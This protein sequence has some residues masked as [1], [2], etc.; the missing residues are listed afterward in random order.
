MQILSNLEKCATSIVTLLRKKASDEGKTLRS[1]RKKTNNDDDDNNDNS[2]NNN[3]NDNNNNNSKNE[4]FIKCEPLVY[5]RARRAV[6]K[7]K[8][9]HLG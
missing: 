6:Q 7:N 1:P 8:K 2:N 5:T 3:N 4:I 9:I